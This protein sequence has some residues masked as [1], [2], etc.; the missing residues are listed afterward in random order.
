MCFPNTFCLKRPSM[1][2]VMGED[3]GKVSCPSVLCALYHNMVT[4][5]WE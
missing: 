1:L 3:W 2:F 4:A 5:D